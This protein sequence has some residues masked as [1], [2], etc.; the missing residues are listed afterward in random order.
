MGECRC[1]RGLQ[2]VRVAGR[3]CSFV[4]R[5]ASDTSSKSLE[6]ETGLQAV[7]WIC[8]FALRLGVRTRLQTECPCRRPAPRL[9]AGSST[10]TVVGQISMTARKYG[11][12]P[13]PG[14]PEYSWPMA[15]SHK[16]RSLIRV[17]PER[18]RAI[19]E[20]F[21]CVPRPRRWR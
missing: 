1:C 8:S 19:T 9:I 14:I 16:V 18:L 4:V 20:H 7:V 10:R 13:S 15:N 12:M 17:G 6:N 11:I 5:V 2:C 21:D 3:G